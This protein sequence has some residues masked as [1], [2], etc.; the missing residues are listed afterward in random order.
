MY[1]AFANFDGNKELMVDCY[2]EETIDGSMVIATPFEKSKH[3]YYNQKINC[4]KVSGGIFIGEDE[5]DF[6]DSYGVLDWGRGVWTYKNTWYWGSLSACVDGVTI[7]FNLGY[8][9]GD[10]SKASE[11]MLMFNGKCI[12]LDD[13]VFNIPKN[14]KGKDEFLKEWTISSNSN[15][16][17]I[18]L[19][20]KPILN[21]HAKTD[22]LV[23]ASIQNQ[24]FGVFDGEIRVEGTTYKI[25]NLT[26][27]CEKVF[28]KW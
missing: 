11:N 26:G 21:R 18:D 7:G 22:I 12:K 6:T 9:F 5:Y 20:F 2:L 19:K 27:F 8:G 13:C 14:E 15:R 3:F 1:G 25:S 23:I 28:N 10:T 17:V 4:L 16:A 24:V